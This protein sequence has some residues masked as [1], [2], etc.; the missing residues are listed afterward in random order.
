MI[1]ARG[2]GWGYASRPTAALHD[3]DLAVADGEWLL[4]AGSSGAGKSTLALAIA[5]LVPHEFAGSWTGELEVAG[6]SV[7]PTPRERLATATQ[8]VF[9][10]PAAQLV[11][12]RVEDDVAFGLENRGWSPAA[13]RARVAESL[14]TLGVVDLGGRL[15]TRLSGGQQQLVALAGALA[16]RPRILVLDEPTSNLDARGATAFYAALADLRA[17]NDRPTVVLIDHRV[18]RAL[19]L[20]D[21]V[22]ALDR[23]GG[24]LAL[25]P[26]ESVFGSQRDVLASEGVWLPGE[27]RARIDGALAAGSDRTS[28]RD[29]R[30]VVRFEDVSFRYDRDAPLALRDVSLEIAAGDRVAL[31]GPNGSGKSTLGRL[32]AGLLPGAGGAVRLQGADPARLPAR[33]LAARATFV[34]QDPVLQFLRDR[35]ADELHA[36]L[37][38]PEQHAAADALLAELDLDRPGLRDASPY[39]LSGGEQRRLSVATALVREPG[40]VVLDEPTYGQDRLRYE[41]LAGLLRRRLDAGSSLLA[42]T[43]DELFAAEMTSRAVVLDEGRVAWQGPTASRLADASSRSTGPSR[44]AAVAR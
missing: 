6:L 19:P 16:P 38:A 26:A 44:P 39:T 23:T 28:H 36:G 5:G 1:T 31:L 27:M 32:G 33:E 2:L 15:T 20:V 4:V 43:H 18:D 42:A 8:L 37:Q 40:L 35:V 30:T 34:F 9:Q 29:G 3:I 22:L 25:G 14:K 7:P 10:E 21:T 17:S 24:P 13:M 12:E 11:M 41:A